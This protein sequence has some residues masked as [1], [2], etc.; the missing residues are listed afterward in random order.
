MSPERPRARRP[1]HPARNTP[2]LCWI[3]SAG[4]HAT[5]FPDLLAFIGCLSAGWI[6]KKKNAPSSVTHLA[7]GEAPKDHCGNYLNPRFIIHN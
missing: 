5:E 4:C 2:C 6:G 3:I 1:L 7:A